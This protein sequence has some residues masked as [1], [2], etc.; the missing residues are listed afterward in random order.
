MEEPNLNDDSNSSMGVDVS[1]IVNNAEPNP[2]TMEPPLLNLINPLNS[3]TN[4]QNNK[5]AKMEAN[6]ISSPVKINNIDQSIQ[7]DIVD[8]KLDDTI[9][10]DEPAIAIASESANAIPIASS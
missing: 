6:E 4:P 5:Q 10:L 9:C 2:A 1:S 8:S 7:S 3:Q